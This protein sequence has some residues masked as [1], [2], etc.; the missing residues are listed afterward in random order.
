MK[1]KKLTTFG[2]PLYFGNGSHE[3]KGEKF[4]YLVLER[5]GKDLWSLFKE[6]GR[7]FSSVTV[8]QIGAQMVSLR[9]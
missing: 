9:Q 8:F 6:S 3:Y 2:M 5:Y 4:R 1:T 7:L